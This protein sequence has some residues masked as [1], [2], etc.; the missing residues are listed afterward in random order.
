MVNGQHVCRLALGGG[1]LARHP[2]SG[3]GVK[4]GFGDLRPIVWPFGYTARQDGDG[5]VLVDRAG[6]I[7]AWEGDLVQFGGGLNVDGVFAACG[8]VEMFQP[9]R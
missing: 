2:D 3:L 9:D 7:V 6:D 4:N 5:A 1:E 8:D